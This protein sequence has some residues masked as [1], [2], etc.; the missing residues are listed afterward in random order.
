MKHLSP[1]PLAVLIA[2]ASLAT[3]GGCADR[4]ARAVGT[5]K[6]RWMTMRSAQMLALANQQ[7]EMGDLEQAETTVRDGLAQ[8]ETSPYLLILAGRIE[9]ERGRLER[10]YHYLQK[11]MAC[12]P[13][14][15]EAYY[16][17]GV[18]LERWSQ[19][20]P[21]LDQYTRAYA[22]DADNVAYLLAMGEM[23][24]ALDRVD[25][26][27]AVFQDKMTYFEQNAGIREAVGRLLLVKGDPHG[28]VE[29]FHQAALLQ[30]DDLQITEEL[31]LAQIEAG[32]FEQ[33][34]RMLT[35]LREEEDLRGRRY[36]DM[37]LVCAYQRAGR[38]NEARAI[39]HQL[40]RQDPGDVGSW[41]RLAELS[42]VAEDLASTLTAAGKVRDLAPRRHEG[43]LFAGLVW[44]RRGESLRAIPLF[45]TAARFDRGSAE[46][47]ILHGIALE[48]SGLGEAAAAAYREALRRQP[49]DPRA[50]QLLA[51]VEID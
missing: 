40:T 48:T 3:L 37:A 32:Q 30:P 43:Y 35:R 46:P 29:L 17:Q 2:M 20:E 16:Y 28:A 50:T 26:A 13:K 39:G 9:L 19:Y 22:M 8:D 12:D 27:L 23:L 47:A 25:E 4:H 34:I 33:A 31:A 51:R 42:W 21:A 1:Y 49:G 36:I 41:I 18:V 10:S 24:V 11:A 7:F 44:H 14:I 38:V 5:A 15:A 45:E 6:V